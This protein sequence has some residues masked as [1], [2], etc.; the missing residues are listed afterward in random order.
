MYNNSKPLSSKEKKPGRKEFTKPRTQN[1]G[2][3]Q[4]NRR[5]LKGQT[6]ILIILGLVIV[7]IVVIVVVSQTIIKPEPSNIASLKLLVKADIGRLI[8]SSATEIVIKIGKQGGYLAPPA[9]S[10][11][12][13]GEKVPYW[14]VC[15]NK[16]IP[17]LDQIT[18]NIKTGLLN[19]LDS[20]D[21]S[22]I[23]KKY[24]K[25]IVAGKLTIEDIDIVIRDKDIIADVYLPTTL[26]G[27]PIEQPYKISIPFGLGR[28]Y[29]FASDFVE[30]NS[31]SRHFEKF[32]SSLF[33]HA[34]PNKFPTVG[35]L[36][37]CGESIIR[38]REDLQQE[39]QKIVDFSTSK[40]LL[41]QA[42][43][44]QPEKK[45]VQS[46]IDS[47]PEEG[48]TIFENAFQ[49]LTS[50]LTATQK[51]ELFEYIED[52][53]IP[54]QPKD[55]RKYLEYYLEDVN[56]K[57]YPDLDIKF[58]RGSN[59]D[60]T[61]FQSSED[62]VAIINSRT[63]YDLVP[64]CLKGFAIDYTM[65]L[66]IV[67]S[68]KS[69]D[70]EF[71]FATMTFI[72][73]SEIGS[74]DFKADFEVVE[75]PC[76][77]KGCHAKVA[78]ADTSGK[79]IPNTKV[80]LG[81]CLL[82][83]TGQDGIAEGNTPCGVSELVVYNPHYGYFYR[84]ESTLDLDTNVTLRRAP[85]LLF[86][87]NRAVVY[88][89]YWVS[90]N[91]PSYYSINSG[92][93]LNDTVKIP[94]TALYTNDIGMSFEPWNT[95]YI[96]TIFKRKSRIN[97]TPETQN[98]IYMTIRPKKQNPWNQIEVVIANGAE[99][100]QLYT[101]DFNSTIDENDNYGLEVNLTTKYKDGKIQ[102]NIVNF[103][104]PIK[105][106]DTQ[107]NMTLDF[108]VADG[109]KTDVIGLEAQ[110]SGNGNTFV[111]FS[112]KSTASNT[113]FSS[114]AEGSILK[115][116]WDNSTQEGFL[117]PGESAQFSALIVG[118]LTKDSGNFSPDEANI[119]DNITEKRTSP[120]VRL[121]KKVA[122]TSVLIDYLPADNYTA[123]IT[124]LKNV[125]VWASFCKKYSSFGGCRR[126]LTIRKP[127][128]IKSVSVV[129]FEVKETDQELF[130]NAF[131]P[132][133]DFLYLGSGMKV[134]YNFTLPSLQFKA[135]CGLEGITRTDPGN[136]ASYL[137]L[138]SSGS[139]FDVPA[140]LIDPDKWKGFVEQY[141]HPRDSF[142]KAYL[143]TYI[144]EMGAY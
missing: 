57:T 112:D 111:P 41:W 137:S 95:P 78:V 49:N 13:A 31:K 6:E 30:D 1:P 45:T 15:Q 65:N 107:A 62:P 72:D 128:I 7:S 133:Y 90:L 20:L 104:K 130:V 9:Q 144:N 118:N 88:D 22:E 36:G 110:L 4:Y 101:E 69:G 82:G 56:N 125:T 84:P 92:G 98:P 87:F 5:G 94:P 32:M 67:T 55:K 73:K 33:Y 27:F 16:L 139:V 10:A 58:Q 97:T 17:T 25:E 117:K 141:V 135:S 85:T 96:N 115:L 127:I 86:H 40:I 93:F 103:E 71:D 124:T 91:D 11:K 63:L 28:T 108:T 12:F 76:A 131:V 61:N 47:L 138:P 52:N 46:Y 21:F 51:R 136:C 42:P 102:S 2:P 89:N 37:K 14:G 70:F 8:Q 120:P 109:Y 122:K 80:S 43:P 99:Q 106:T 121:G 53:Y 123:E 59:I 75:D 23:K 105:I 34:N 83:L 19:K 129:D 50:N 54:N 126:K 116:K 3:N 66:P 44:S 140:T 29:Q 132:Y 74:C 79:P 143:V 81:P 60:D 134:N 77:D 38:S 64:E 113:I 39:A 48:K 35:V 119:T 114:S 26:E 24:G 68:V 18:K 142:G 100:P